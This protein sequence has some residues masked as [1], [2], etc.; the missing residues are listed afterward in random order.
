MITEGELYLGGKME[1]GKWRGLTPGEIQW[2]NDF[3][4]PKPPPATPKPPT[5]MHA[6]QE[7]AGRGTRRPTTKKKTSLASL[8][9]RRKKPTQVNSQVA[10]G[11]GGT[12][13]N[14]GGY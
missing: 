11:V 9:I 13:L 10:L 5:Q 14:V 7:Q 6:T 12:G 2:A 1:N 3:Y 4:Y 8:R